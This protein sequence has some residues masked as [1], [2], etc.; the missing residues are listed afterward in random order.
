MSDAEG[1]VVR[2]SSGHYYVQLDNEE[3]KECFIRGKLKKELIYPIS[4]SR[5]QVVDEVRRTK[6]VDPV[7]VGDRVKISYDGVEIGVIEEI[8]P[9]RSALHRRAAGPIPLRQVIVANP[10]QVI[11]VFS[12][13]TPRFNAYFLDRFL[14]MAESEELKTI[15]CINKIDL[16]DIEEFEAIADIYRKIGYEVLLT[17]AIT[18][19]G[20][21]ELK[22]ILKNKLSVLAGPSGVG[23]STLLNVI[24]PGLGL[25]VREISKST[26]KGK[27]TTSNVELLP[28]KELGGFVADT[29]GLRELAFW[30]VPQE[31]LI[32]LF[33]EMR[34]YIGKCKFPDCSHNTEPDCA[35]KEAVKKGEINEIRYNSFLRIYRTLG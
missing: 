19:R 17:S 20:V 4:E 14:A 18:G 32:Y 23:K 16:A 29:P 9:R 27:H 13:K 6:I 11:V 31:D 22:D 12:T 33:P 10:D 7:A 35:V 24:E 30:E 26:S 1:I 3:I 2:T 5:R 8:I 25:R 28:L 21:E 34:P 15:I